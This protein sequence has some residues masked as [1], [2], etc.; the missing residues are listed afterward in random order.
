MRRPDRQAGLRRGDDDPISISAYV[1]KGA[2]A[3]VRA[4]PARPVTSTKV[5]V[6][7]YIIAYDDEK[8][9]WY[10]AVAFVRD[11]GKGGGLH[12]HRQRGD[13]G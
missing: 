13:S 7:W 11:N 1:S 3:D 6:A 8:K 4:K 5:K 12:R 2:A 9:G 10:E